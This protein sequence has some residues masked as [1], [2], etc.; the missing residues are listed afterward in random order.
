ME[1]LVYH[2]RPSKE[3]DWV[4]LLFDRTLDVLM[5]FAVHLLC[6]NSTADE[7]RMKDWQTHYEKR[8]RLS[9]ENDDCEENDSYQGSLFAVS[10]LLVNGCEYADAGRSKYDPSF[11]MRG[12]F[13][14]YALYCCQKRAMYCVSRCG[15]FASSSSAPTGTCKCSEIVSA[16]CTKAGPCE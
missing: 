14:K 8:N 10:Y 9:F 5:E 4:E 2:Y 1:S 7:K 16:M 6:Q 3:I 15:R 11:V 13:E 12:S